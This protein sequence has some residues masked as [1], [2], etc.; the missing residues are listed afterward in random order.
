M[1]PQNPCA[2]FPIIADP[3]AAEKGEEFGVTFAL[4]GPA[5]GSGRII[6]NSG[7]GVAVPGLRT[8]TV[9]IQDSTGKYLVILLKP[10]KNHEFQCDIAVATVNFTEAE[11]VVDEGEGQV[12][13]CLVLDTPIVAPLIVRMEAL[14]AADNNNSASGVLLHHSL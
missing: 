8:A 2:I 12:E 10:F 7:R 5:D 14:E 6:L 4:D 1:L 11:Y 13:V 9:I 3:L